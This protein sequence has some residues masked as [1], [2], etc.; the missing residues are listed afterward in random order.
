MTLETALL[1]LFVFGVAVLAGWLS[2][3]GEGRRWRD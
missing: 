3:M 2:T 1:L